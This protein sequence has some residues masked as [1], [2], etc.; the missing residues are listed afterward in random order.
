MK[1]RGTNSSGR[2]GVYFHKQNKKWIANI[3]LEYKT[4]YLGSFENKEEASA[5]YAEAAKTAFGEFARIA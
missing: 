4:Q 2:K 1:I 3:H 5:A